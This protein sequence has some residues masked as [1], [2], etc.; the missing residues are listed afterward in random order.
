MTKSYPIFLLISVSFFIADY[1][2]V[3]NMYTKPGKRIVILQ[4]SLI[5]L[6]Q[7]ATTILSFDHSALFLSDKIGSPIRMTNDHI[8]NNP[9]FVWYYK[10]N[11]GI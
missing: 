6:R 8:R 11:F 10:T 9:Q 4:L 2:S 3:Y 7:S 5:W 1:I